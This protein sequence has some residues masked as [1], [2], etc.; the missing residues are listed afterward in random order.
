MMPTIQIVFDEPYA[1]VIKPKCTISNSVNSS[2]SDEKR[3]NAL[4]N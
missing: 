2:D 3:N 4:A 1:N